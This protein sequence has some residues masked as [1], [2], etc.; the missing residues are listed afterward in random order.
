MPDID[1]KTETPDGSLPSDGFLFGADSQAASS[2]S[3]YTT[4]SVATRLL[5]STTLSGTTITANAPVLNLSQTWNNAAVTFTGLQFNAAG[6]SDANSAA[7]SL[8][9]DLQVS[10]ASQFNLNKSGVAN[11][12]VGSKT[13][14]TIKFAGL[15][16]GLYGRVGGIITFSSGS[17]EMAQIGSS[18]GAAFSGQISLAAAGNDFSV[19]GADLVL[20]RRD[21]RNLQLGAADAATALA[22]TFS[23]QSV[24]A[25]TT[26]GAGA[27]FTITGSQGTGSGVGGSIIFQVAPAGSSGS[28]QNALSTA[29]TIASD[30][31]ANF[32]GF[33]YMKDNRFFSGSTAGA[34]GVGIFNQQLNTSTAIRFASE[35]TYGSTITELVGESTNTLAVR[36]GTAQQLFNIY[37][38]YT[39]ASNFARATSSWNGNDWVLGTFAAGSGT[40]GGIQFYT[41]GTSRWKI[42]TDGHLTATVDNTYD[43]GASG[44]NRPRNV[45]VANNISVG[46]SVTVDSVF[47]HRTGS[48]L[49]GGTNGN[50]R[51]TNN[52]G[53]DFDRLQFG[54][55]TSSFPALKRNSTALETKLADDSAYAPHAMQYLDVTDGI[56]APSSATGRA[57]IYVDTADGDLKVIFADGTVKTIVTDT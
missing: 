4:Q 53:T 56:T 55:T 39:N 54:G 23:V 44:A 12:A 21:V 47:S 7:A 14:P 50:W 24:V 31:S 25:G 30:K 49:F 43:I 27:N 35:S 9:L 28:T 1:L 3:V 22:Q 57:R 17:V 38:T 11:F 16:G 19:S 48:V 5:G 33:I 42:G 37:N 26:D 46:S 6:S 13:S 41:A 51:L 40:A 32:D 20:R 29:L 10:G 15:A 2:P 36:N 8:L 45:F 34:A 52:A 18:T